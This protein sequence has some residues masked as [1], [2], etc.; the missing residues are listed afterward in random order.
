LIICFIF[1]F[2][3]YFV[4]KTDIFWLLK[5]NTILN[6][7]EGLLLHV[8]SANSWTG[9]THKENV[10]HKGQSTCL[11]CLKIFSFSRFRGNLLCFGVLLFLGQKLCC[12]LQ[13]VQTVQILMIAMLNSHCKSER[14]FFIID[15]RSILLG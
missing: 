9:E 10:V 8:K 7:M 1:I 13:V 11:C 15:V 3:R 12:L 2:S 6:K 5:P 4:R 14:I